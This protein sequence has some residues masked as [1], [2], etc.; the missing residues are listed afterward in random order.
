M[1]GT[2]H[3]MKQIGE[4]VW[5]VPRTGAMRV[6]G[7]IYADEKLMTHIRTERAVEQVANVATLPGVIRAVVTPPSRAARSQRYC[8]LTESRMRSP[9]FTLWPYSWRSEPPPRSS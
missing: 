8:G 1:A 2:E 3:E 9:V 7:R 6:P 5:E 4:C